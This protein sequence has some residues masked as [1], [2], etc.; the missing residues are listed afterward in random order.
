MEG[1]DGWTLTENSGIFFSRDGKRLF[2]GIAP[3]IPPKD[4]SIVDFETA[5]LDIWNWDAPYTPPQQLKSLERTLKKTYTAVVN[6]DDPSRKLVPLTTSFFDN[7]RLADGGVSDVAVSLD[8]KEYARSY[9]W[10][11]KSYVDVDLVSLKDGSRTSV[12]RR[13]NGNVRVSPEGKFL[14]WFDEDGWPSMTRR[15]TIRL[16]PEPMTGI[17]SGLKGTR[18]SSSPTGMIYGKYPLTDLPPKGSPPDSE[19]RTI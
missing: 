15:T 5:K 2:T 7:I 3:L 10:T 18:P 13:L 4:T 9:V 16:L 8:D 12:A 1:T 17:P 19:G 6:L 11:Y 14:Y